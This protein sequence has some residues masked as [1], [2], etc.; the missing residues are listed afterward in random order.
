MYSPIEWKKCKVGGL[1]LEFIQN[2]VDIDRQVW[3]GEVLVNGASF[4]H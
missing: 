4:N 1:G 3:F 2:E